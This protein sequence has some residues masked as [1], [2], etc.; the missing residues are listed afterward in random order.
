MVRTGGMVLFVALVVF[1]IYLWVVYFY[2]RPTFDGIKHYIDGLKKQ[3][4]KKKY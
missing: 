1:V 4:K 2:S 3:F